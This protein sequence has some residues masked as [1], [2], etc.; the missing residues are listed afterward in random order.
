MRVAETGTLGTAACSFMAN[1]RR[2]F[3]AVLCADAGEMYWAAEMAGAR[4]GSEKGNPFPPTLHGLG[5]LIQHYV[6]YFTQNGWE[7][8][9]TDLGDRLGR[10]ENARFFAFTD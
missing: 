3:H 5:A 10:C 2:P 9:L 4:F 6:E 1:S 7:P 8:E